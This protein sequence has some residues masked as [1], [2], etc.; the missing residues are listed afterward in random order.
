M[1]VKRIIVGSTD[2]AVCHRHAWVP[3]FASIRFA[4]N[5]KQIPRASKSCQFMTSEPLI[6]AGATSAA[7]TGTIYELCQ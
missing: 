3:V 6:R 5:P 4:E 2:E 1:S 7:K